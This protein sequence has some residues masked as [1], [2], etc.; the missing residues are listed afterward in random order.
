MSHVILVLKVEAELWLNCLHTWRLQL[1]IHHIINTEATYFKGKREEK[2]KINDAF[3]FSEHT[4]LAKPLISCFF[5]FFF[6]SSPT[7]AVFQLIMTFEIMGDGTIH[8]YLQVALGH[9]TLEILM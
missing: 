9:S 6:I 5:F 4:I 2:H 1:R 8:Y 7:L 3:T